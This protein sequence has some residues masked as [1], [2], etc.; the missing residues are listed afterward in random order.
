MRPWHVTKVNIFGDPSSEASLDSLKIQLNHPK[1]PGLNL[2][3][4]QRP[5]AFGVQRY[6]LPAAPRSWTSVATGPSCFSEDPS[7]GFTV[8]ILVHLTNKIREQKLVSIHFV[9]SEHFLSVTIQTWGYYRRKFS[10]KSSKFQRLILQKS[11]EEKRRQEEWRREKTR[12]QHEY[13]RTTQSVWPRP[14]YITV[15]KAPIQLDPSTG[16]L[17]QSLTTKIHQKAM[18]KGAF[19]LCTLWFAHRLE[20]TLASRRESEGFLNLSPWDE[21]GITW[22]PQRLCRMWKAH[23]R[24]KNGQV[25]IWDQLG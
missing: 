17:R 22:E 18:V 12:R 1:T 21:D 24:W 3:V 20:L 7:D 15:P 2:P 25:S 14:F 6:W 9:D 16:S 23:D 10:W 4:Q 5:A 13:G 19:E 11:P 8:Y